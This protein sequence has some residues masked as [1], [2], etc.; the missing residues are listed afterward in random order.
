MMVAI[1][2]ALINCDDAADDDDADADDDDDN[3]PGESAFESAV[4]DSDISDHEETV[5]QN[6]AAS[7]SDVSDDEK[8]VMSVNVDENIR[9]LL[10][11]Q[12]RALD[13][14]YGVRKMH[15]NK[16]MIGNA[17]KSFDKDKIIVGNKVYENDIGL[18]ELLFKKYP[19]D[20]CITDNDKK[21]YATILKDTNAHKKYYKS[22]K[23]IRE[24]A[25]KKIY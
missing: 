8:T 12:T 1:E 4:G 19:D 20:T 23:D 9:L 11:G 7:V 22:K 25:S 13:T 16:L 6:N 14:V 21:N 18:V 2:K 10:K 24:N 5:I 15:D 17:P 3:D